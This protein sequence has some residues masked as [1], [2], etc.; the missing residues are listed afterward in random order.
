MISGAIPIDDQPIEAGF[1][2][3][4]SWLRNYITP[5]NPD[6]EIL[7]KSVIQGAT[8]PQER[9]ISAWDWVA[10]N[11]KYSPF[12]KATITIQGKASV[13]NDFWQMP[14]MCAH[15]GVGNCVN[16]AFLLTSLMRREWGPSDVYTVLGNLYNG[17]AAGH[18][19]VEASINGQVWILESTRN[20]VPMLPVEKGKRYEAV[21][22]VND[23]VIYAVP[24]RTIMTPFHASYSNWLRD[25][26][27]WAYI[28][29]GG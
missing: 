12:I 6:I 13:Q 2:G 16:K 25:Y 8:N 26:L 9:A 21:H 11:V 14:S 24:G 1:F 7:W 3:A 17:H 23:K 20:D 29:G 15:T 5:D 4:G 28:N 19:W 18:A 22:Y 27:H 10:N